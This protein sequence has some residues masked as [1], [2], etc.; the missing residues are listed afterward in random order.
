M[1]GKRIYISDIH[2]NAGKGF[3]AAKGKHSYEW[4]GPDEAKRFAAFLNYINDPD[5]VQE[6]IIIGDL[7]DDWVI[8]LA[9]SL[10]PNPA[11]QGQ[12][13]VITGHMPTTYWKPLGPKDSLQVFLRR[14]WKR[15]V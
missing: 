10:Q 1:G 14:F 8:L 6:V 2:M 9:G 7:L 12:R 15:P 11:I 13:I 3:Q 4:L 5:T